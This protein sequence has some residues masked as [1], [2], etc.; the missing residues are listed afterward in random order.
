MVRVLTADRGQLG[1]LRRVR[2]GS[3][4]HSDMA[5]GWRLVRHTVEGNLLV[6]RT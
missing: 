6:Q 2:Q 1:A 5:W 4:F 3:T